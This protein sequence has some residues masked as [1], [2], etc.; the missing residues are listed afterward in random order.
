MEGQLREISLELVDDNP[1]NPRPQHEY[2]DIQSLRESMAS[3]GLLCPIQVRERKD[4]RFQ[5]I[6]GHRRVRAAR[7]LNWKTI[8][9]EIVSLSDRQMFEAALVEN[10]QRQDLSDFQK[11]LA[12]KRLHEQFGVR[13]EDIAKIVGYSREHVNNYVR[14]TTLFDDSYLEKQPSLRKALDLISEHHS[15]LLLQ[16]TDVDLRANML[17]AVVSDNL[18]VRELQRI[19]QR[20]RAWFDEVN[21]S[22]LPA[23]TKE[24]HLRSRRSQLS[25]HLK[26]SRDFLEIRNKLVS[27]FS[28]PR[29]SDFRDFINLRDIES[30]SYSIYDDFPPFERLHGTRA[31]EKQR[32]WF[33]LIA[34]NLTSTV[35]DIE[36]DFL[37][38]VALATLYADYRKKLDHSLLARSRG[39]VVFVR[40]NGIWRIVHEHWSKLEQEEKT[41]LLTR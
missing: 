9:A 41:T 22:E 40:R 31:I 32:E 16:I 25:S 10:V 33:Y 5:L 21:V 39:T 1:F 12:F 20:F 27:L 14:M 23:S 15:R 13:L 38:D 37:G 34:P 11:G 18:S 6:Y 30:G 36:V 19:I 29:T 24:S 7:S 26:Q 17:A 4:G 8:R 3:Q 35:R 2:T 28:G